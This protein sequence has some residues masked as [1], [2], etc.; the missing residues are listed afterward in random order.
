[1]KYLVLFQDNEELAHMR[2]RHMEDHLKFLEKNHE[3]FFGAGPVFNESENAPAGGVWLLLASNIAEVK[4]LIES[5]PLWETGLRKSVTI[6]RWNTV[7]YDGKR[8]H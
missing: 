7:F 2:Q 6:L 8:I 5:D 3:K 1:M 4:T